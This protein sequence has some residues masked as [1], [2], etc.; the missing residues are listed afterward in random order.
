M[1]LRLR[2]ARFD[3]VDLL[4]KW[5]N[6][7]EVRKN[8]FVTSTIDYSDHVEWFQSSIK[9]VNTDIFICY[10]GSIPVGQ[11]RLNYKRNKAIINFSVS[12]SF[13]GLGYGK[14]I[15]YSAEEKIKQLRPDV[16]LLI[17]NVKLENI[18][19]RKVFEG[20]G[21]QKSIIED[22]TRYYNYTKT[23]RKV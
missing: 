1:K 23:I 7:I 16:E 14:A 22:P 9:D 11:I 10:Q 17:G 5:A 4:F 8:S 12:E 6:D 13:R 3:D 18:A 2:K 21:F 20:S 15:L 19:S